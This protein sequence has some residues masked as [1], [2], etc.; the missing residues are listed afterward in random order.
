MR[1]A[2]VDNVVRGGHIGEASVIELW[3]WCFHVDG[4]GLSSKGVKVG[5]TPSA[6][7]LFFIAL[8]PRVFVLR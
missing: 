8:Q 2:D 4:N 5:T 6:C 7:I 1:R 3:E